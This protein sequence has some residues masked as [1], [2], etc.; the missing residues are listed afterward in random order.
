VADRL[1]IAHEDAPL[2]LALTPEAVA[3]I[4]PW[5]VDFISYPYEWSFGQLKDAALLT[6]RAQAVALE[7]GFTLRDASAYNGQ[8]V[9]GAPMLIDSLSFEPEEPGRPWVAYRQ[10][11]QHFLAPLALAAHRDPRLILLLR[12][13]LDGSHRPRRAASRS[14]R[15][16]HGLASPCT[17]PRAPPRSGGA[18]RW[19][20]RRG[21]GRS[22][23]APAAV[24]RQTSWPS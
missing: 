16:R 2:D 7:R 21:E 14:A 18:G 11:C 15:P 4:R 9:D 19:R 1:L 10:F 6:L 5:P 20:R 23:P 22:A 17:S 13:H 24:G 12:E 8:F 3:V